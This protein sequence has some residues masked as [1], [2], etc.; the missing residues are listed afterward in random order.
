MYNVNINFFRQLYS[1]L[2]QLSNTYLTSPLPKG[3]N[4]VSNVAITNSAAMSTIHMCTYICVY[5]YVCC[6]CRFDRLRFFPLIIINI[7][8]QL[9]LTPVYKIVM[10]FPLYKTPVSSRGWCGGADFQAGSCCHSNN[11]LYLKFSQIVSLLRCLEGYL[12][13]H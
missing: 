12:L 3:T 6:I 8:S 9:I 2:L 11:L 7:S 5:T 10:L 13:F 1:I 4:I